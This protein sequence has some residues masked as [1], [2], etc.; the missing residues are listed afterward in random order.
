MGRGDAARAL[1]YSALF[2]T[3]AWAATAPAEAQVFG[4][5]MTVFGSVTDEA[6]P[7]EEGLP[8]EAYVGNQV[9]GTGLTQYTGDGSGRITVYYADVVSRE[10]RAGCGAPGVDVRLK[11]G[12]R[13]SDDIV[14]W[15]AGPVQLDVT[16][17]NATP[18]PIPTFT[19]TPG[20]TAEPT[21]PPPTP[22]P[23]S[24]TA[25]TPSVSPSPTATATLTATRTATATPTLSGGFQ[26]RPPGSNNALPDE[27]DGSGFPIWA[28]VIIGIG[29]IV[30]AGGGLGFL[31]ARSRPADDEDL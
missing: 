4:P 2:A 31:L 18:A 29:A 23:P 3:L 14:D 24:R 25:D 15:R 16:F 10:Q 28:A 22:T 8:V 20:G 7:V 1:L 26:T 19:P 5:P 6:G 21:P 17:G 13:F 27:E 9:C 12:E 30:A 11:I